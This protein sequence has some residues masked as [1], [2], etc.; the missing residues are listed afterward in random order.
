M[1]KPNRVEAL[2][3]REVFI[4]MG[5]S[6]VVE[7]FILGLGL[8]LQFYIFGTI[9]GAIACNL[10]K[11][12]GTE[13]RFEKVLNR[14]EKMVNVEHKDS[15]EVTEN[16]KGSVAVGEIEAGSEEVL[17]RLEKMVNV[18]HKDS[19]EVA[20]NGKGSVA[21]GEIEAGSENRLE[22]MVNAEHKDSSDEVS[23]KGRGPT[24]ADVKTK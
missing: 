17:S 15:N 7:A 12:S 2:S 9:G 18:G 5:G 13:A 14:L 8:F 24:T 3:L 19:N 4:V 20:E 10:K 23:G 6:G 16:G 21:V 1:L 11:A 22:K